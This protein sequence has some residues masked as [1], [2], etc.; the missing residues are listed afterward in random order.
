M[1]NNKIIAIVLLIVGAGLIFWGYEIYNSAGSQIGR[2]L[3]GEAP[4]KAYIMFI[5]GAICAVL[6]ISKLKY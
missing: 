3:G 2:A 6:G 1:T 5:G 4:A